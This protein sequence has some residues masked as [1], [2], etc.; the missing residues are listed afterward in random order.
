MAV[1]KVVMNTSNGE[2]TLID[3]TNDTVTP[4]KLAKGVTAHN[5]AGDVIEGT[6]SI[7]TETWVLTYE[8]GSTETKVVY[9]G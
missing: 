6:L 2:Q 8:D 5:A 3:L 7:A 1:N 4:D 9:M